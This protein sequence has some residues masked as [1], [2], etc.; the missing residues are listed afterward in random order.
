MPAVGV[1]RIGPRT[2]HNVHLHERQR[3]SRWTRQDELHFRLVMR[4]Q[5]RRRLCAPAF[6][7][8]P[9]SASPTPCGAGGRR[10]RRDSGRMAAA[11]CGIGD[12]GFAISF[13]AD[14]RVL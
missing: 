7:L 3:P 10:L 14:I 13:R 5:R 9:C 1:L 2:V 6:E 12:Y 4:L 8:Q 11:T